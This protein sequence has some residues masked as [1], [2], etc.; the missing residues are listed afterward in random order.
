MSVVWNERGHTCLRARI[1]HF[2]WFG[3][4]KRTTK[5]STHMISPQRGESVLVF[6]STNSVAHITSLPVPYKTSKTTVKSYSLTFCE[7]DF[8][9]DTG[10]NQEQ[11][12]IPLSTQSE[13]VPVGGMTELFLEEGAKEMKVIVCFLP[14]RTKAG[15]H[16]VPQA[17]T[18]TSSEA[19][20]CLCTGPWPSAVWPI[21]GAVDLAGGQNVLYEREEMV[22][23]MTKLLPVGQ[24]LTLLGVSLNRRIYIDKKNARALES[25]AMML[26]DFDPETE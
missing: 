12:T 8:D 21:S 18:A 20:S 16:T 3:W 23:S 9:F 5:T 15:L 13:I 2:T 11:I 10:G 25:Y 24:R 17:G 14:D 22:Y 26:A 19:S 1:D 7:T 4:A 6:N